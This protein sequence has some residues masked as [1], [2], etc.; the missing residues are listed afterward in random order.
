MQ[1]SIY[2]SRAALKLVSSFSYFS[3]YIKRSFRSGFSQT[4]DRDPKWGLQT[5]LWGP[6]MISLM[7]NVLFFSH[8]TVNNPASSISVEGYF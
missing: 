4:W 2:A 1:F 3:I 6:Q 7:S 5:M 8:S